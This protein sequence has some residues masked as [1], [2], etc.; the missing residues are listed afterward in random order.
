MIARSS[1]G[2]CIS[3]WLYEGRHILIGLESYFDGSYTGKSWREGDYISLAGQA[4][5]DD[6]WREFDPRWNEI[7]GGEGRRPK[8]PYIH[9]REATKGL[10][11]FSWRHGWNLKKVEALVIA[12]LQYLQTQDKKRFHQFACSI[13]LKAYRKLIGEGFTIPAPVDLCNGYCSE[14]VLVWFLTSYPGII[15]AAHYFF[16]VNEPFETPFK[17]TWKKEKQCNL[18]DLSAR[19]TYWQLIKTVT[20]AEMRDKPALQAADLLAWASNRVLTAP[21]GAFA[22]YLEQIMKQIIPSFWVVFDEKR[23]R[24]ELSQSEPCWR[25]TRVSDKRRGRS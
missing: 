3:S 1:L 21:D 20:T 22:K 13:D 7:L 24:L 5:E 10:G 12:L 11:P 6:I 14:S 25:A 18:G 17:E 23:L 4:A 16:D 8:T 19:S 15:S 9:M 2:E